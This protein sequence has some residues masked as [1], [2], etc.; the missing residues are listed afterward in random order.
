MVIGNKPQISA[1]LF[2]PGYTLASLIANQFNEAT[3]ELHTS[4]LMAAGAVL[5]G[6]SLTINILARWLVRSVGG[7]GAKS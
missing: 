1:S 3:G 5:F 2:E 6:V 7:G 4:A